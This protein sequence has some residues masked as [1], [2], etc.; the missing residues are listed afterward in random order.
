MFF[1]VEKGIGK[2]LFGNLFEVT[3]NI[4][5]VNNSMLQKKQQH[6][7]NI[8]ENVRGRIFLEDYARY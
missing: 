8:G 7:N 3:N 2:H 1:K 4:N 5:K 6:N